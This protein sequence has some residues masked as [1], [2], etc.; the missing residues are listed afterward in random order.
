M[1]K[2]LSRREEGGYR[3]ASPIT[4]GNAENVWWNVVELKKIH[5][6]RSVTGS[7]GKENSRKS[8]GVMFFDLR[9][10]NTPTGK[11]VFASVF[12]WSCACGD[13]AKIQQGHRELKKRPPH[14]VTLKNIHVNP[15]ASTC[16]HG[17]G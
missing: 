3:G 10:I 15:Q 11:C 2:E 12:A 17:I 14:R 8:G 1:S 13:A 5:G 9:N 16:T 7:Q 6:K 4:S